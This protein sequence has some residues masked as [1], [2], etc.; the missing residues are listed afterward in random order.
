MYWGYGAGGYGGYAARRYGGYGGTTS[1]G[2]ST[3][4]GGSSY[5][6]STGFGGTTGYGGVTGYGGTSSYAVSLATANEQLRGVLLRRN[7]QLRRCHWYGGTS[8]YRRCHWLR[9]TSSYGGVTGYGG[10]D[11]TVVY[12]LRRC[13]WLGG[14]TARRSDCSGGVTASPGGAVGGGTVRCQ[15]TTDTNPCGL[16]LCIGK[17]NTS[18][19]GP[20]A[21]FSLPGLPSLATDS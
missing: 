15:S 1:R 17:H 21:F 8:S 9:R 12:W 7:E 4:Y 14:V 6:G 5:A 2:G 3:G 10:N 18:R 16:R 13:H 19:P 20:E 11:T